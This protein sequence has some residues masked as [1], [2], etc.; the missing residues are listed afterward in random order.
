MRLHSVHP[1]SQ[2][3]L[4]N[5]TKYTEIHDPNHKSVEWDQATK[6]LTST[7]KHMAT[8][9]TMKQHQDIPNLV[10]CTNVKVT[11]SEKDMKTT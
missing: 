2:D 4:W 9:Q 7:M 11:A 10:R 8:K 5:Q 1:H 6:K 3:K